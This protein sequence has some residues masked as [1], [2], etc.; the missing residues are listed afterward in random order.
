MDFETFKIRLEHLIESRGYSMHT[1]A[2]EIGISTATLSRY[3]SGNR[4]PD[5]KY[6]CKIADFC[7]VSVD[8]LLGRDDEKY[9][10]MPQD[11]QEVTQLYTI[12][13]EDDRR[14]VQAVLNKYRNSIWKT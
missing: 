1:F 11:L 3:I 14:V 5:L 4:T 12:A 2:S 10:A 7:D 13:S 8:W 9:K 6:I